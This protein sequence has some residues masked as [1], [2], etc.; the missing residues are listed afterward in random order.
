MVITEYVEKLVKGCP[1]LHQVRL[2]VQNVEVAEQISQFHA[3]RETMSSSGTQLLL[4]S[5]YI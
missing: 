5:F 3:L 2:Y 1:A 4:R